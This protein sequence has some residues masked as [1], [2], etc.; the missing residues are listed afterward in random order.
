M[1]NARIIVTVLAFVGAFGSA[2]ATKRANRNL[3]TKVTSSCHLISCRNQNIESRPQCGDVN[4]KFL[5]N[6][7]TIPYAGQAWQVVMP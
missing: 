4:Q 6:Q 3:Y 5:D 2:F 1:K 7:C